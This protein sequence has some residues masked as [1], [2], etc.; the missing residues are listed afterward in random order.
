MRQKRKNLKAVRR[1]P[2]DGRRH[3]C[4]IG[5]SSMPPASNETVRGRQS[6]SSTVSYLP[7]LL[8]Q[9]K[10]PEFVGQIEVFSIIHGVERYCSNDTLSLQWEK[11]DVPNQ[12]TNNA[13]WPCTGESQID[14]HRQR[15]QFELSN[16]QIQKKKAP[17]QL[18]LQ[19]APVSPRHVECYLSAVF[20]VSA[21]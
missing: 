9:P 1:E 10:T 14:G 5:S 7:D 20:H 2:G 21:E 16:K 6:L 3:P 11:N 8:Y 4:P 13:K 18:Q 17:G 12:K 19:R 15:E